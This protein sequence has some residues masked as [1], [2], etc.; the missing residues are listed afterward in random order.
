[1]VAQ[2][3]K[4]LIQ[5]MS[6]VTLARLLTPQDYGLVAMV[7][8]LIGVADTFRDFPAFPP[9]QFRHLSSAAGSNTTFSG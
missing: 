4:I 2:G 9:Q 8:A 3:S 6:V 7:T 1:M 5:L